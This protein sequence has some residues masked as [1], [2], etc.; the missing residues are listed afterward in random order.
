MRKLPCQ[1]IIAAALMASVGCVGTVE[2][3]RDKNDFERFVEREGLR[4]LP[5][6]G[7]TEKLIADGYVCGIDPDSE[8]STRVICKKK[9]RENDNHGTQSINLSP[10]LDKPARCIVGF[11]PN[12]ITI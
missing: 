1:A 11:V 10:S 3:F 12:T 8:D 9:F 5:I 2:W 4:Q 6:A 7:A